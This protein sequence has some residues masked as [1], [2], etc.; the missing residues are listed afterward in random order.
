[1]ESTAR[2][3]IPR[4]RRL[5]GDLRRGRTS[6]G[7]RGATTLPMR[8]SLDP[9]LRWSRHPPLDGE[10]TIDQLSSMTS[11]SSRTRVDA[12]CPNPG[13]AR[14]SMMVCLDIPSHRR[15][16][17]RD[18]RTC[19][20]PPSLRPLRPYARLVAP[21]PRQRQRPPH[22]QRIFGHGGPL[23]RRDQGLPAEVSLLLSSIEAPS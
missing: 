18:F 20:P 21:K 14:R 10:P 3:G 1:M 13:I 9:C 22:R 4:A 2:S 19:G 8:Q 5:G 16:F 17:E 11:P 7:G 12:G 15:N 6:T 23:V